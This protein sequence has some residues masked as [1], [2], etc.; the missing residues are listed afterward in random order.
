MNTTICLEPSTKELEELVLECSTNNLQLTSRTLPKSLLMYYKEASKYKRLSDNEVITLAKLKD[1]GNI[2]ARNTLIN[3]NLTLVISF[4]NNYKG[5]CS[6]SIDISDLIQEGNI[7]LIT[8]VEKFDYTKGYKFSTY[9]AWWI[10]QSILRALQNKTNLIRIPCYIQA[11]MFKLSRAKEKFYSDYSR[12]PS[13]SELCEL[14]NFTPKEVINLQKYSTPTLS[15]D[16][17]LDAH[18]AEDSN[19]LLSFVSDETTDT[20]NEGDLNILKEELL[21]YLEKNLPPRDLDILKRSYGLSC[22]E[23]KATE[24]SKEYN[25]TRERIRQILQRTLRELKTNPNFKKLFEDFS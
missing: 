6:E 25:L 8:A 22:N 3:S 14:T 17:P 12:Y 18:E 9:A 19:D 24:I 4:V 20:S 15:L 23:Q 16:S 1:E 11:K 21:S 7:G 13:T 2:E 5:L 10:K